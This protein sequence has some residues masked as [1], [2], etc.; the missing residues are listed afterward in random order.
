MSQFRLAVSDWLI[1]TRWMGKMV[2]DSPPVLVPSAWGM[3]KEGTSDG[4]SQPCCSG[5]FLFLNQ[6]FCEAVCFLEDV[7]VNVIQLISI[8]ACGNQP[9]MD[10]VRRGS[11]FAGSPR[12]SVILSYQTQPHL[13]VLCFNFLCVCVCVCVSLYYQSDL[14]QSLL[15]PVK[16][17]L[18]FS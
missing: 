2:S 9:V 6:S 1:S 18:A 13:Y 14:L 5:F 4:N 11:A 12:G 8:L 10:E 7:Q 17:F 16:L 3:F 15:I